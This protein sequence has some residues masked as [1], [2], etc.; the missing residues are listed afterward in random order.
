MDSQGP[1]SA[2]RVWGWLSAESN[3]YTGEVTPLKSDPGFPCKLCRC[4][5]NLKY[6]IFFNLGFPVGPMPYSY[7]P[8]R[9]KDEDWRDGNSCPMQLRWGLHSP[10]CWE[11]PVL[12]G[13]WNGH[14]SH[15]C[16]AFAGCSHSRKCCS[17]Q[18]VHSQGA[19]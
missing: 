15:S 10:W 16:P 18:T 1:Q 7:G 19:G 17:V 12:C 2:L 4:L 9:M 8:A 14:L 11:L 13:D 5:C 6:F 3:F